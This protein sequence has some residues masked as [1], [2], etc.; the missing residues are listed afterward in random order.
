MQK[1]RIVSTAFIDNEIPINY[2]QEIK[3][4]HYGKEREIRYGDS[5]TGKIILPY[6]Y[7]SSKELYP[8]LYLYH[9]YGGTSA[10]WTHSNIAR[11]IVGNLVADGIISDIIVVIP[12]IHNATEEHFERRK[13]YCDF[14]DIL[15]NTLMPFIETNFKVKKGKENTALAGLSMGAVA[16]L[17]HATVVR[18]RF[19]FVGAFSP[20][21]WLLPVPNSGTGSDPDCCWI[22]N[23]KDFI[24]ENGKGC[25]AF[26]GNGDENFDKDSSVFPKYYN[27][28]LDKNHSDLS[29]VFASLERGGHNWDTFS[30]LLYL[31]LKFGFFKKI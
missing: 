11:N 16:A 15:S 17:Y 31:F 21:A 5:Y 2:M 10:E 3:G 7:D 8:V 18:N 20:T 19:N 1:F 4:N 29:H 30:K 13:K 28:V 14:K 25:F 12:D 6:F 26:I 23:E 24:V 22:K 9:G 27:K